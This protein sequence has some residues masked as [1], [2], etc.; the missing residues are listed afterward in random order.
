VKIL[1][2]DYNEKEGREYIFK[3]TVGSENLRQD[4]D[5]NGVVRIVNFA[6]LKKSG[7]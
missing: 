7:C 3:L 4:G 6:T 5:D 2:G 1:L